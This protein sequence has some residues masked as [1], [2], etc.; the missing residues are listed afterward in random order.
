MDWTKKVKEYQM[1]RVSNLDRCVYMIVMKNKSSYCIIVRFTLIRKR[2]KKVV[3]LSVNNCHLLFNVA[4]WL[5]H[6]PCNH[7]VANSSP[8]CGICP[9]VRRT[10]CPNSFD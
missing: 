6:L 8:S 7:R 5:E 1:L 3:D 10:L 2:T 9:S 4:K